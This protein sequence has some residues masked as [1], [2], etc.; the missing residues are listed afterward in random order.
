ML[1]IAFLIKIREE[2]LGIRSNIVSAFLQVSVTLWDPETL[3]LFSVTFYG[4]L[5][6]IDISSFLFSN[7][8]LNFVSMS[9]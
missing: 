1:R 2:A 3:N 4:F 7:I 6:L 5:F 9:I 8:N